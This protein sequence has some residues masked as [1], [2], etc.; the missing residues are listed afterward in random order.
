MRYPV[1]TNFKRQLRLV[2]YN[3]HY[4]ILPTLATNGNTVRSTN[5]YISSLCRRQHFK[6]ALV[7]FE[8]LQTN[9]NFKIELGTYTHLISAC[10]SLRSL[11]HGKRIHDHILSSTSRPD[12]VLQNNMLNMYRKCGSLEDVQTIF[13]RMHDRNCVSWSR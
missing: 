9:R 5:E 8:L 13:V 12:A 2:R 7:A 3:H 1:T 10:S 6:E 4:H 11:Y